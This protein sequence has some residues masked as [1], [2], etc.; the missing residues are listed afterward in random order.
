MPYEIAL[1]WR[2]A[3]RH[4]ERLEFLGDRILDGIL[5]LWLYQRLP[6]ASEGKL[7]LLRSW[8]GSRHILDQMYDRIGIAHLADPNWV[9]TLGKHARG[10]ILEALI[11]AI[12]LDRGWKRT[13]RVVSHWYQQHGP[14]IHESVHS[15]PFNFKGKLFEWAQRK[16]WTI[17][18]ETVEKAEPYSQRPYFHATLFINGKPVSEGT[19]YRKKEAEENAARQWYTIALGFSSSSSS[20]STPQP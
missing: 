20:S 9:R 3:R 19:G 13:F 17:H 15:I 18:F 10:N 12:Y 4:F 2:P 16:Q 11:G 6:R 14:S 5:G 1:G 7:S 8:L